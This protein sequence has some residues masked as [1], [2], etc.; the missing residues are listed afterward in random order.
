MRSKLG[1]YSDFDG[2]AVE[3]LPKYPKNVRDI[4]RNVRKSGLAPIE[5]WTAFLDGV[6]DRDIEPL[7]I[8]TIRKEK[9]RRRV[10]EASLAEIDP[11][12]SYFKPE[13]V[14]YAGNERF[15]GLY[16]VGRA[17]QSAQRRVGMI[18][19][20]P[21]KLVPRIVEGFA[22]F[23]A[24]QIIQSGATTIV[25]GVVDHPKT[26]ARLEEM[27]DTLVSPDGTPQKD[28]ERSISSVDALRDGGFLVRAGGAAYMNDV[29]V[30]PIGPYSVEAGQAFGAIMAS[31]A[32]FTES[33]LA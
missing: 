6:A 19:D 7:G 5:G 23:A 10:T 11:E 2:T 20:Q 4:Y 18:D 16:L 30:V 32:A 15:K 25:L 29:I 14:E 31:P 28:F 33:Q 13:D 3:K 24:S 26:N 22:T 8:V 9:A 1:I 12:G 27:R 21:Q 17:M